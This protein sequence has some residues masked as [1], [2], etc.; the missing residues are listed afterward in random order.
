MGVLMTTNPT[1]GIVA[2]EEHDVVYVIMKSIIAIQR[3][4]N[5]KEL[6]SSHESALAALASLLDDGVLIELLAAR[7]TE[8]SNVPIPLVRSRII[9][10]LISEKRVGNTN[11][12]GIR[13]VYLLIEALEVLAKRKT[14]IQRQEALLIACSSEMEAFLDRMRTSNEL[15]SK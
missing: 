1:S 9:R 5:G 13:D 8:L 11:L 6:E 14:P 3:G 7:T 2:V 15:Y 12:F 4:V 10:L